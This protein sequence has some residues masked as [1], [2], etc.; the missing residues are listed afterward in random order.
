MARLPNKPNIGLIR[1]QEAW[2]DPLPHPA[3]DRTHQANMT[4]TVFIFIPD[5]DRK[6]FLVAI[7]KVFP[8]WFVLHLVLRFQ[9]RFENVESLFML[10]L[11]DWITVSLPT[12]GDSSEDT[13]ILFIRW[14]RSNLLGIIIQY[15]IG[16]G[17]SKYGHT[18]ISGI[19]VTMI[20]Y[21]D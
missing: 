16:F 5:V 2:N 11:L 10:I 9:F 18:P 7:L 17:K 1:A 4:C 8:H 13:S 12:Y 20:R 19:L 3:G 15:D 6:C 21:I 14:Q